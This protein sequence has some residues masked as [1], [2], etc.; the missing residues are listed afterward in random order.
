MRELTDTSEQ[1]LRYLDTVMFS[2]NDD[3]R[4]GAFNRV[5]IHIKQSAAIIARYA[6]LEAKNAELWETLREL[7]IDAEACPECCN[8][9]STDR[10]EKLLGGR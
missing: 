8:N 9:D 5:S 1:A 6:T 4:R 3:M 7:W 10:A 2:D